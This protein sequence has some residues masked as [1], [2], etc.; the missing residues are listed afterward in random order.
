MDRSL[1]KPKGF[2]SDFELDPIIITIIRGMLC[3]PCHIRRAAFLINVWRPT[4]PRA[5]PSAFRCFIILVMSCD[6]CSLILACPCSRLF[7]MPVQ[8]NTFK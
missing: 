8:I 6:F 1:R 2:G 7:A 4:V 3:L 5:F